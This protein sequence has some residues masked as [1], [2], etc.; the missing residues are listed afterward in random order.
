MGTREFNAGG[1]PP[2]QGRGEVGG[3]G[4]GE[5]KTLPVALC[6]GN[7]NKLRPD[8]PYALGS[9]AGFLLPWQYSHNFV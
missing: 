9:Y 3:G 7:R 5:F 6:Y 8:E 2:I 1:S 4:G